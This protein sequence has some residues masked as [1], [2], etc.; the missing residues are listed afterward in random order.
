[1]VFENELIS[2]SSTRPSPQVGTRPLVV[3]P[4]C[5]NK[6]CIMDLQP[7][8]SLIRY[9]VDQGNTVFLVS[10]RNP[11]EDQGHR[12]WDDYLEHGP[13]AAL[14]VAR[15]LCR[16][17]QVNALGFCVG[18]T[19]LTSALAVL[20]AGARHRRPLALLTTLLDFSDT[21]EI[22]LHRRTG[23]GRPRGHDWQRRAAARPGSAEHLPFLRANDLVW[24]YV[25]SKYLKGEKPPAFDLLYWNADS[26][27][28]PGP[29]PAGT[30][31]TSTTT[32]ICGFP[33]SWKCAAPGHR[34]RAASTCRSICS[35][36]G[37][38]YRSRQSAYQSTRLL[39]ARCASSSEPQ[40][41]IAGVINPAAKNKRS[42]WVNPTSRSM[43]KPARRGGGK[44]GSWWTDWAAWLKTLAGDERPA[45]G[46][47]RQRQIQTDR[48]GARPLRPGTRV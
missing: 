32:T 30:C 3:V 20:R 27:N 31:A 26:T 34:Y 40:A 37:R 19:I 9:M 8:N 18:G 5:I 48:T 22:G 12:T 13:I 28:L 24:N 41:H 23:T 45:P 2:S 35:P 47:T 33:A 44:K 16:T 14:H 4:P 11:K 38:P 7:D 36:P 29:L 46:Q 25:T 21:G 43:P 15:N 6:F 10:W 17:S 1:M 39:G 42:Y